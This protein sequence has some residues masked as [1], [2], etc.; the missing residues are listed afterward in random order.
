MIHADHI[1]AGPTCNGCGRDAKL[2]HNRDYSDNYDWVT[3]SDGGQS[4]GWRCL[5]GEGDFT[6]TCT[7]D[8]KD[9]VTKWFADLHPELVIA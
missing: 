5:N 7:V 4:Y 2:R 6:Y 1:L 8:N 3:S 9:Y